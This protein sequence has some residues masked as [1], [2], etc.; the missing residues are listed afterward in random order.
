MNEQRIGLS[1]KDVQWQ[2]FR[3]TVDGMGD[4]LGYR[5]DLGI[6]DTVAA[7]NAN[8]F[9]TTASCEGHLDHGVAAPWIDIEDPSTDDLWEKSSEAFEIADKAEENK[10]PE[11]VL[12]ALYKRAHEQ[13]GEAR[14]PTLLQAK[15]LMSFLADFY[16][17]REVPFDRR[18]TLELNG[19]S[20]RIQSSGALVQAIEDDQT[21]SANLEQYREEMKLF[22]NYLKS[23]FLN[24]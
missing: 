6:R 7:F 11:R 13:R 5:V 17:D 12:K 18:L 19:S 20:C 15:R 4:G 8:G 3:E 10:Q 22:S 21:K 9:S 16:E 24:T 23:K 2:Q 1:E 14:R